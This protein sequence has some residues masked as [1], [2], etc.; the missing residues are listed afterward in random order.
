MRHQAT[1]TLYKTSQAEAREIC[2]LTFWRSIQVVE[3][4]QACVQIGKFITQTLRRADTLCFQLDSKQ[5]STSK[6]KI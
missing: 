2:N 1:L 5:S 6:L 4:D 3:D